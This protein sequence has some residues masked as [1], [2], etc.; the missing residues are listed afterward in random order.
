VAADWVALNLASAAD[1]PMR[2]RGASCPIRSNVPAASGHGSSRARPRTTAYEF[3][4]RAGVRGGPFARYDPW[5]RHSAAVM[6]QASLCARAPMLGSADFPPHERLEAS[7]LYRALLAIDGARACIRV[8]VVTS[9][10]ELRVAWQ[11]GSAAT[12]GDETRSPMHVRTTLGRRPPHDVRDD[13]GPRGLRRW[14][15]GR[16]PVDQH[17]TKVVVRV[18]PAFLSRTRR[19]EHRRSDSR[20]RRR[21]ARASST[22]QHIDASGVDDREKRGSPLAAYSAEARANASRPTLEM[23]RSGPA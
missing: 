4:S 18:G 3:A 1:R 11:V 21:K 8:R 20:W 23:A 14:W 7:A 12:R 15:H 13:R 10:G 5:P 2:G 17:E 9:V 16:E 22:D 19:S 6:V